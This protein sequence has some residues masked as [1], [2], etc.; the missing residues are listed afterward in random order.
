MCAGVD[1]IDDIDVIRSGGM[2]TLFVGVHA[3]STGG[4]CCGVHL[5]SCPSA[6]VGAA[7]APDGVVRAGRVGP[8][9]TNR[10]RAGKTG[11]AKG[12]RRIVAQAISGARDPG[13]HRNI[14]VRGESAYGSRKVVT[15]CVRHSAR[16]SLVT[17]RSPRSRN[18][19]GPPCAS[20]VPSAI[21]TPFRRPDR[22]TTGTH[23]FGTLRRQPGLDHVRRDRPQA[24][25]RRRRARRTP[26][27]P[28]PTPAHPAPTQP[29]ALVEDPPCTVAQHHRTRS[30][31]TCDTLAARRKAPPKHTGKAGRTGSYL[32]PAPRRQGSSNPT[33]LA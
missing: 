21:P 22:R 16:F 7:R 14:L 29:L 26:T 20:P 13:A 32:T 6:G 1:C 3:P 10:L 18:S 15:A 33:P 30:T 11:A 27:G 12:A 24:A 17:T 28:P 23:P 2:T 31:T 5:R 4:R 8:A 25:A 19:R 9:P